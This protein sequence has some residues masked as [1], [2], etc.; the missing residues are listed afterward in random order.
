MK[1]VGTKKILFF[2]FCMWIAASNGGR[3]LFK[4]ALSYTIN[5]KNGEIDNEIIFSH[6]G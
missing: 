3:Y 5:K 4:L 2:F 1:K 6:L